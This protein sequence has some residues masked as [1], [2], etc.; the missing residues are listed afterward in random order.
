MASTLK[1]DQREFDA[2]EF[3]RL[4]PEFERGAMKVK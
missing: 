3:G 4:P 1:R 2:G